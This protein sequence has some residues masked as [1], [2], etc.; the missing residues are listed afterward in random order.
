MANITTTT[1]TKIADPKL[2]AVADRVAKTFRMAAEKAAAHY[3]DPTRFPISADSKSAEHLFLSRMRS[4]SASKM[5]DAAQKMKVAAQKA[6][7]SA[8]APMA[9]RVALYGD[10][11]KIDLHAATAVGDQ[12]SALEFPA[13]LKFDMSH[14]KSLT[15]LHG[16]PLA[17]PA[18]AENP[19][20]AGVQQAL[21]GIAL[22]VLKVKCV[23]ETTWETGDDEIALG[24]VTVNAMGHS[25]EVGE[26]MVSENFNA[27]VERV[28][29]P[30]LQFARFDVT[31][32][33]GGEVEYA[34]I[35]R[36]EAGSALQARHGMTWAQY[37]QTFNEL[38]G[39]GYR[40]VDISG[41]AS[42]GQDLYAAIWDKT[43]GPAYVT[44]AAMSRDQY[45]STF[46]ELGKQGFRLVRVVGYGVGG[47]DLYAAIWHKVS[48]PAWV[49]HHALSAAEF[50]KT[51]NDLG[52][53][54]YR[55]VQISGYAIDVVG[56][57]SQDLY[58]G[59]WEKSPGPAYQARFGMTSDEY[60]K[61]F[62]EFGNQ[63]YTLTDISAYSI[64]RDL[65][66]AAI[67]QK[68]AGPAWIA[69]HGMSGAEYQKAFNDLG[70]KGYRLER[71]L[72]YTTW[73]NFPRS[74]FATL[75]IAEKNDG[76][77][78]DFLQKLWDM[79]KDKVKA[80]ILAAI[81]GILGTDICPIIGTAIGA[82]VGWVLG[83][84]FDLIKSIFGDWVFA[85][86]TVAVSV[87]SLNAR[88]PGGATNSAQGMIQY[89]GYG[90]TYQLTF[91]WALV[92]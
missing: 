68:S 75:V 63:G 15:E 88:W 66:Y 17:S 25:E 76:D 57:K 59:I 26:S 8:Q 62:N 23:E 29:S 16:Q 54:G 72:G 19:H 2:A 67:W 42:G 41:Y 87:P 56:G 49:A 44:H 33:G 86:F 80:A 53:Q 43:P 40:Q 31:Q 20:A 35:W 61:L 52:K 36:K 11:A 89:D 27:G 7:A 92:P 32:G 38:Q 28:Y 5:K 58:T 4:L 79:V 83:E 10:L 45:Q 71:V 34:A 91:D 73:P 37:V 48:G 60:Q 82:A 14:L 74:Y 9:E 46:N 85:P 51:F 77:F 81:G 21:N 70:S 22:R 6:S 47:K 78:A 90:G 24:G 39:Q 55:L 64:G 1:V 65:R 69:R 12:E 84:I 50:Q 3:A 18:A 30:P 13:A